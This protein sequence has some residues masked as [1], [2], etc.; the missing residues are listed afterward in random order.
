MKKSLAILIAVIIV[1]FSTF[2]F[3]NEETPLLKQNWKHNGMKGTYDKAELQKGFQVYQE[4][5]SSCHGM[6]F[7]SYRDL[8]DLGYNKDEIKAIASKYTVMDGPNDEG[9]MF[10]RPAKA[11]DRFK[12]PYPNKQAARLSNNGSLPPDLSL[13]V[14]AREGGAD[15][16]YSLLNGYEDAPEDVELID[17]LNYNKFFLGHQIAMPQPLYDGQVVYSNG[18]EASLKDSARNVAEFLTW[19]SEPHMEARKRMGWRVLLF[20]LAFVFIMYG[21]KKS[22]WSR[23]K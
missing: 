13:I 17:G 21:A 4:V 6:K 2:S 1:S 14:K 12:S 23:L 8:A 18:E 20:M 10:E 15:Y 11:S 7:L 5:C 9:E 3:A 16:I 22:I 19:A